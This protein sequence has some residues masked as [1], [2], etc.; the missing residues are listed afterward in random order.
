[1]HLMLVACVV[2]LLFYFVFFLFLLLWIVY[3]SVVCLCNL[4]F[5]GRCRYLV[6]FHFKFYH[7]VCSWLPF[8]FIS[9]CGTVCFWVTLFRA[10]SYLVMSHIS[11]FMWNCTCVRSPDLLPTKERL[12]TVRCCVLCFIFMPFRVENY[13][14]LF[15]I[16]SYFTSSDFVS[17]IALHQSVISIL[18]CAWLVE[19]LLNYCLCYLQGWLICL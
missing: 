15:Y 16:H 11:F 17:F 2:S 4:G 3:W 6:C 12:Y 14:Q 7:I 1:M 9:R 19:Y 18:C 10:A 8:F 5:H 13:L